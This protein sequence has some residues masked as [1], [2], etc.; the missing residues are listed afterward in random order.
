VRRRDGRV[1]SVE[2]HKAAGAVGVLGLHWLAPLPQ[3]GRLLVSQAPCK[4]HIAVF[5]SPL[6]A[7]FCV[8]SELLRKYVSYLNVTNA[9]GQD[10]YPRS[11]FI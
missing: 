2:Q 6:G 1:A 9:T 8:T 3:H 10:F 11:G 5:M 7:S 4:H